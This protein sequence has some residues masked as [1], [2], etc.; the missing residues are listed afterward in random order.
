MELIPMSRPRQGTVSFVHAEAHPMPH[1]GCRAPYLPGYQGN[2]T[3]K[4][5]L[6]RGSVGQFSHRLGPASTRQILGSATERET[7]RS[8]ASLMGVSKATKEIRITAVRRTLTCEAK[9]A[10]VSRAC[11][12]IPRLAHEPYSP[13]I[14]PSSLF[15]RFNLSSRRYTAR[16]G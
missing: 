7:E 11:P 9:R 13:R 15:P 2:F 1:R 5:L 10:Y 3:R 8:L 12:A 4:T 16:L 6:Y 14:D